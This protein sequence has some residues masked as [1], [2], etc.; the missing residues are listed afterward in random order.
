MIRLYDSPVSPCCMKV[1]LCLAEKALNY[2]SVA[3][4]LGGKANLEAEYLSMNPKGVVPTLV[5][6]DSTILESTLINEYLDE[7]YPGASLK[8]S[9]PEE[10]VSMRLW[11]KL[12]DE[13]LHP[14]N[15]AV[16]WPILSLERLSQRDPDEVIESLS[17]H[18]DPKRV[19]RQTTIFQEG[20]GA[21]VVGEGLKVFAKTLEKLESSLADSEYLVGERIT[22]AD[23]G[24]LPYVNEVIRFGLDQMAEDK[25]LTRAWFDRMA[26]RDSYG[27]AIAG[28]LAEAQ[29][30][31]IA[32]RGRKAW[33]EMRNHLS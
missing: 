21:Q 19:A 31:A 26:T 10:K 25:P 16:I 22:L 13:E 18:P 11:T 6:D 23:I 2:E 12:I 3:V 27:V 30:D 24:I 32:D 9:S 14:A 29:W 7:K 17:R 20:Y 1:R 5:D 8:P 4:D 28:V 33:P 15:G